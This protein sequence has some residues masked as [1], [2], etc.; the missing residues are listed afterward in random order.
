MHAAVT[1]YDC[2]GCSIK[3]VRS[4]G[5]YWAQVT[6]PR[7][8][9]CVVGP[10]SCPQEALCCGELEAFRVKIKSQ[11]QPTLV[12]A[13]RGKIPGEEFI[14]AQNVDAFDLLKI[15]AIGSKMSNFFMMVNGTPNERYLT[16][17]ERLRRG[18][19]DSQDLILTSATGQTIPVF[20]R[21]HPV[22]SNISLTPLAYSHVTIRVP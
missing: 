8:E 11:L 13:L 15:R 10:R 3:L 19:D 2:Q 17:M 20:F 9:I 14:L 21:G 12:F 6:S 4:K 22:L 18:K 5:A 7:N 16:L 1:E